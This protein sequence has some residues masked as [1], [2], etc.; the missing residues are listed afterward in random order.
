MR[1]VIF[2]SRF[3]GNLIF[4]TVDGIVCCYLQGHGIGLFSHPER[5]GNVLS[6]T[7]KCMCGMC[8]L[9]VGMHGIIVHRVLF[10]VGM[11]GIIVQCVL[12][13]C[14]NAQD[15]CARESTGRLVHWQLLLMTRTLTVDSCVMCPVG[16][17]KLSLCF[18][19]RDSIYAI[20]RSLLT[21]VRPSVRPSVCLSVPL[22]VTRVDQSKTVTARITQPSPQSSPM[23]L[24]SSRGTAP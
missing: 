10:Y 6:C 17:S 13:D 24:V 2:F 4:F 11:H 19:A 21:P 12:I 1:K 23:T 14:R 20:A 3:Q 15:Q 7:Y 5:P 18:L 16:V 8:C 22:S 9:I